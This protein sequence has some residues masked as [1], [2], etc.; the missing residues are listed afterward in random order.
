MLITWDLTQLRGKKKCKI[1]ALPTYSKSHSQ[2]SYCLRSETLVIRQ[3]VARF[4]QPVSSNEM[5]AD[6]LPLALKNL[7][8]IHLC[9]F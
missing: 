4:V 2:N 3:L 7:H 8:S 6:S 9:G 5:D 1:Q